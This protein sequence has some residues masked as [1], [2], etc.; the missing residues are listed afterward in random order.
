MRAE[1][2]RNSSNPQ[3]VGRTSA[4]AGDSGSVPRLALNGRGAVSRK[5][6]TSV[7]ERS[8]TD[9]MDRAVAARECLERR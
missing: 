5:L 6:W 2:A 7:R 3:A 9:E 4:L 1:D 8:G